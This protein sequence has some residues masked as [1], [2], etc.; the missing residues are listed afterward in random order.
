M[1]ELLTVEEAAKLLKISKWTLVAWKCK[2]KVPYI[3][4]GKRTLFDPCDLQT[5]IERNKVLVKGD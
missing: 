4:L 3:K 5:F 2:R 1:E